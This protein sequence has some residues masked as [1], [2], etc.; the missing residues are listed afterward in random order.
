MQEQTLK[1]WPRTLRISDLSTKNII[2]IMDVA[3][4]M[5][6]EIYITRG[7][8]FIARTQ[9]RRY[10]GGNH[11]ENF[12]EGALGY[13]KRN[14]GYCCYEG[15]RQPSEDGEES[16]FAHLPCENCY[17]EVGTIITSAGQRLCK[18]CNS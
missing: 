6:L 3:E 14:N 11:I 9:L 7:K 15:C 18:G 5:G 13:V 12:I 17:Q 2:D 1:P 4:D 16:C 10:P 8:F